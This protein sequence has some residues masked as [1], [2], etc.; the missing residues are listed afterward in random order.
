M[1]NGRRIKCSEV[2]TQPSGGPIEDRDSD[3]VRKTTEAAPK[4]APFR[5]KCRVSDSGG[6]VTWLG[7]HGS[8]GYDW[9]LWHHVGKSAKKSNSRIVVL[10]SV[11]ALAQGSDRAELLLQGLLV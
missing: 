5:V 1:P 8:S 11:L 9:L 7:G 2:G 10:V 4:K 6:Y 3:D